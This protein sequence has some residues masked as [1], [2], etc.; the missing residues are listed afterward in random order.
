[1]IESENRHNSY[2]SLSDRIFIG[3]FSSLVESLLAVDGASSLDVLEVASIV[4]LL[5]VTP[6]DVA[7]A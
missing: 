6:S 3:G 7:P 1:M 4:E 5:R 2:I